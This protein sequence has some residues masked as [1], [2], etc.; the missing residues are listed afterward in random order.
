MRHMSSCMAA[1]V[2]CYFLNFFLERIEPPPLPP[3]DWLVL[4]ASRVHL[5]A[6]KKKVHFIKMKCYKSDA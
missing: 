5:N 4:S 6:K 1:Y 3:Y 2:P